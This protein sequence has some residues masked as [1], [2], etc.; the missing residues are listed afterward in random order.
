MSNP[1]ADFPQAI[2]TPTDL[3]AYGND[4]LGETPISHTDVH[5]KIEE[6]LVATQQK[7]GDG[8]SPAASANDGQVLT[9]NPDGSS[10]WQDSQGGAVDS[11][12]GHI[13]DV[14]LGKA[15]I[16]LGNADNTS[17]VN[18]PVSTAAAAAIAAKVRNGAD[19]S[20][21]AASDYAN[22]FYMATDTNI[23]Y[24]SDGNVWLSIGNLSEGIEAPAVSYR[25]RETMIIAPGD[26]VSTLTS[27]DAG[28][29][30][31]DDTVDFM[32][33]GSA[34]KF[35]TGGTGAS[36]LATKNL[37]S[38]IDLSEQ[39]LVLAI[40]CDDFTKYSDFQIR[41][42]ADNFASANFD[43]CKPIFT[44]VSQR[45]VEGA[46]WAI[47][48]I[49]R[50][51]LTSGLGAGQWNQNGTGL[52]DWKAVNSIR[53]KFVDTSG[54][55]Q[56]TI[57]INKVSYFKRP[58]RGTLT[59]MFDD[60]RQTHYTIARPYMDKYGM[61][62]TSCTIVESINSG[63]SAYMTPAMLKDLQASS[64]WDVM[65]HAFSN[66]A[67]VQAHTLGYDSLTAADGL[68]DFLQLKHYI[69]THSYKGVDF[70]ALPH[71]TWSANTNGT[72]NANPDVLGM[73]GQYL[74]ACR[75]TYS[76]TW[77]T[78][79]AADPLKIRAY[80]ISG[81]NG[82]T[83]A[84]ILALI[85][86]IVVNHKGW[87]VLNVH[88]L[89]ASTLTG[90]T[91]FLISEFQTLIDGINT[92]WRGNQLEFKTFM[93]MFTDAQSVKTT[94][95]TMAG[96]LDFNG[97]DNPGVILASLSTAQRDL[98][99]PINGMIIY[100]TTTNTFQ[101]Y[102]NGAWANVSPSVAS[103]AWGTITGTLTDQSDLATVLA[104]KLTASG[105]SAALPLPSAYPGVIGTSSAVSRED[106]VH[107]RADWQPADHAVVTWAYDPALGSSSSTSLATQGT[108]YCIKLHIP[109]AQNIT[110]IITY[111]VTAGNTLTSGQCFAALY[112]NGTLLGVTADQA[113][114]W[115]STGTK[116]MP[117]VGGAV[118]VAAGEVEVVF[119]YNGTTGPALLRGVGVAIANLGLAA[120]SS[121]FGT[122]DTGK[123]TTA[124]G[125]LGTIAALSVA[126]WA[127][128]S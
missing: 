45:W 105:L 90:S 84:S 115:Q 91:D 10:S 71:G 50:G 6:E 23:L 17:D 79:P 127:A 83:A 36:L 124:P 48:T 64:K 66:A 128:L 28:L 69:R 125:T 27:H 72:L 126:Y 11:V 58:K 94:G 12:N 30:V 16:G 100:N 97:T 75:T 77:E 20:K 68:L 86:E 56:M 13:G 70:L 19:A 25:K 18:K 1:A 110:N 82:D 67:G 92:R 111:L 5:G 116:L 49:N 88:N 57:R 51:A 62:G 104:A 101:K 113:T 61:R 35:V 117:I 108:L 95:G 98:I 76:Q 114:N 55:N 87:L 80:S 121:R 8:A 40:K 81:Q 21:G 26:T 43:Y 96:P 31:S 9:V 42:S 93:D 65:M 112:Q 7:L 41:L 29:T 106:H 122:A 47:I 46:K 59:L 14:T 22:D 4:A 38:P 60:S 24:Q 85:D 99:P 33:G 123:T 73:I 118:A 39:V 54:G 32:L 74:T 44:S 37:S 15:D 78:W 2:H 119:W 3:T 34:M 89:V 102:E 107:P 63:S 120:A 53:F 103:V 52:A 109:K